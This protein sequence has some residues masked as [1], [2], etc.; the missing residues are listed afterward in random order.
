[1]I[2][3][4]AL[5][6]HCPDC[7]TAVE[8]DAR[9]LACFDAQVDADMDSRRNKRQR[10]LATARRDAQMLE[11]YRDGT[12]LQRLA[13]RYGIAKR[14]VSRVLQDA[15]QRERRSREVVA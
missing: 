8:D 15:R 13:E 7:G 3:E 5:P 1:M 10:M 12:T 14:T 9:C 6:Y 4:R 11:E 2:A